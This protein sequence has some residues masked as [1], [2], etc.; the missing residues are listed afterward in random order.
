LRVLTGTNLNASLGH[1]R[2]YLHLQCL[3]YLIIMDLLSSLFHGHLF[4]IK[5]QCSFLIFPVGS[6]PASRTSSSASAGMSSVVR[7]VCPHLHFVPVPTL[8]AFF[9]L[10]CLKK[11]TRIACK[12]PYL[13]AISVIEII[14][15]TPV[16]LDLVCEGSS[17]SLKL[18]HGIEEA[19]RCHTMKWFHSRM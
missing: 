4:I 18:C 2:Y 7:W 9:C 14:Y 16:G 5:V 1:L 12:Q 10:Y 8:T 15:N 6:S 3:Y 17:E 19:V 11:N 13:V